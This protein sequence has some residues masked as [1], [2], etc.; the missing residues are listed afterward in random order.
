MTTMITFIWIGPCQEP[1]IR[2]C[3]LK[4]HKRT[5]VSSLIIMIIMIIN[6]YDDI[7]DDFNDDR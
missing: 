6:E 4:V 7:N 3:K 2:N 5:E 1:S